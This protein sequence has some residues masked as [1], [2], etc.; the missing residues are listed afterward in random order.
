V[1][2][3]ALALAQIY[4]RLRENQ[5]FYLV[6]AIP[7]QHR[8]L[9]TL[10]R[11]LCEAGILREVE[12]IYFLENVEMFAMVAKLAGLPEGSSA[13]LD[14]IQLVA[15]RRVEFARSWKVNAPFHLGDKSNKQKEDTSGELRGVPASRGLATG[16]ARLVRGPQDFNKV[17]QGEIII[18]PATTPAWTPLFGAAGGLVTEFGGLLSHSGV[19]AREYGLPAVLGVPDAMRLI[20]DGDEITVD[21]EYGKVTVKKYETPALEPVV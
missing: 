19:V 1:F 8:I 21:G 9:H 4:F 11:H 14:S 6:M 16:K 18:A 5:Q 20:R 3:R 17:R 12:D 7:L 2:D 15:K 10:G 13:P